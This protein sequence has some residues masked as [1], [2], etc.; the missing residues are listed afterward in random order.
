M[1]PYRNFNSFNFWNW[2]AVRVVVLHAVSDRAMVRE[3]RITN[4]MQEFRT[5]ENSL[6][7][8]KKIFRMFLVTI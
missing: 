8:R 5:E 6:L 1:Q 2:V 4:E 7:L 3:E